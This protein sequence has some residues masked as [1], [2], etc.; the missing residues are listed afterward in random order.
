MR[1]FEEILLIYERIFFMKIY[2]LPFVKVPT[3]SVELFIKQY[4]LH[5]SE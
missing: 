4:R 5:I 1:K 3:E 2:P